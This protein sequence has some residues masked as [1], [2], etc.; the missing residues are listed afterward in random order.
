[1][2]G[3]QFLRKSSNPYTTGYRS[4]RFL[5]KRVAM[6][7]KE[8]SIKDKRKFDPNWNKKKAA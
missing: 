4:R 7:K 1:M 8:Q 5:E 3:L 2:T 6:L